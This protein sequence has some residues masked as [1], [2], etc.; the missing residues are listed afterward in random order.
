MVPEGLAPGWGGR[1]GGA[2]G[3][4]LPRLDSPKATLMALI[5]DGI[6]T[7]RLQSAL[8]LIGVFMSVAIELMGGQSLPVAVGGYLPRSTSAGIFAA[9]TVPR[10]VGRP[11]AAHPPS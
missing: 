11:A 10:F 4:Q 7:Q 8:V 9:G 5:A 1:F 6:L 3:P 2:G